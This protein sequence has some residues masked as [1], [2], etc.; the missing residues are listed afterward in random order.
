MKFRLLRLFDIANSPIRRCCEKM[1]MTREYPK[2]ALRSL[3]PRHSRLL[4]STEDD[5]GSRPQEGF[6]PGDTA[7]AELAI[8][9]YILIFQLSR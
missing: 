9:P 6:S 7:V 4:D 1:T 2:I 3:E 8:T 5:Q